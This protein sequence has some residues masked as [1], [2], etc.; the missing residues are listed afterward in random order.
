MRVDFGQSN[1]IST[2][3][4]RNMARSGTS[5]SSVKKNVR[6]IRVRSHGVQFRG[7]V[8][9]DR[10]RVLCTSLLVEGK[11]PVS[12]AKALQIRK[13]EVFPLLR[14]AFKK[15][16]LQLSSHSES[17]VLP[18]RNST[19]STKTKSLAWT[20]AKDNRRCQLID[21]ELSGALTPNEQS[22]LSQLQQEMLN[23]RRSVAPLP[24]EAA[25]QLHKSLLSELSAND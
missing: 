25:R 13:E 17:S 24:L 22:E 7:L 21:R 14:D 10:H 16:V 11:S 5:K 6:E 12:V 19:A 15:G 18:D 9:F 3:K 8:D 2:K 23:Y 1:F 20:E 4:G